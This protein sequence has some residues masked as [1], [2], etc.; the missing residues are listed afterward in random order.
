MEFR[1][2]RY[3]VT[4]AEH[5]HFA[6]AAELLNISPP[7]LTVQIQE[8][9]RALS[10]QLFKRT[11][12]SV[13]LTSAGEL[14]LE[15][16]RLVLAQY[17]RAE[18][19]GRRAGRGEIGRIEIGYVGSAA[20]AGVLQDQINRFST[21]WPGV[22]VQARELPMEGLPSLI[23]GGQIDIGFV[24][25]PMAYSRSLQTHILFRDH[26]CLALEARHPAA[27]RL[28]MVP[29]RSLAAE[30]FIVPEQ[31][32]G[33]HEVAR[34]GRF[35][36]NVVSRPGSLLSVLTQVSLG[37]GVAVVPSLVRDIVRIPNVVFRSVA[38]KPI[39]S[40]V[41]AVFRADEKASAVRN[42]VAQIQDTVSQSH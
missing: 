15:E 23:E 6:R 33:S 40:E 22:D 25:L 16:A 1:H 12:R 11:K 36:M 9:E 13:S 28:D 3:F 27:M 31:E 41:A 42:F 8:I 24:R 5:L 2:F 18:S 30:S 20:Y 35:Q 17:A 32:A 21:R 26:F 29:S 39:E 7:T 4:L 38:G 14:F 37:A 10:V 34:R 19:V